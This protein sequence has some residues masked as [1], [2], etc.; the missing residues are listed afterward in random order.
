MS[1]SNPNERA[2][3]PAA[4]FLQWN[5]ET[6]NFKYWDKKLENPE[7][8]DKKGMDVHVPL[9]F[10]FLV[11]DTLHTITGFSDDH[12]SGIYS[13][14]VKNL[15][16]ETINIKIKGKTQALGLYDDVKNAV[17]GAK[18]A[19]SVYIGYFEGKELK[20]GNIKLSGASIGSWI[21]HCKTHKAEEGAVKVSTTTPGKKGNVTYNSPVFEV[22]AVSPATEA[23]AVDLDII[24]QEYL[25]VYLD[26]TNTPTEEIAEVVAEVLPP[27]TPEPTVDNFAAEPDAKLEI[28]DDD[29]PS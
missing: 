14:E 20:I 6:K 11:L 29:L 1:R 19:Q 23:K 10:Q 18:Y 12:G 28:P 24:L 21:E 2:I 27:A 3:N 25:K 16:K 9:P 26:A 22:T 4:I 15:K 8:P 5:S 7:K 13:N 17:N